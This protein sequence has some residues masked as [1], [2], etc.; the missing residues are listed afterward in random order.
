V[1]SLAFPLLDAGML[2]LNK[3]QDWC[4]YIILYVTIVGPEKLELHTVQRVDAL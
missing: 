1:E 2:V 4:V 3:I